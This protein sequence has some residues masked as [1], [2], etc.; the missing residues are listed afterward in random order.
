M[1]NYVHWLYIF[2]AA[3]ISPKSPFVFLIY[4]QKRML[5]VFF[6]CASILKLQFFV[7]QRCPGQRWVSCLSRPHE[8]IF[9][10]QFNHTTNFL[11]LYLKYNESLLSSTRAI[12]HLVCTSVSHF[13]RNAVS[14]SDRKANISLKII[15]GWKGWQSWN[16]E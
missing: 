6:E 5:L 12:L 9:S 13:S 7:T 1:K 2:W 11:D 14:N 10:L 4:D 8:N 15:F 16:D 3:V